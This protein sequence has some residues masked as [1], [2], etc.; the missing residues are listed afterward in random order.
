LADLGNTAAA[1]REPTRT[2]IL[3]VLVGPSGSGKTTIM[4]RLLKSDGN[5]VSVITC[6]TRQPREGEI[7]GVHYHFKTQDEFDT[8]VAADGL[9]E[10]ATVFGTS[11]GVPRTQVQDRIRRGEDQIIIVDWQGHRTLMAKLP[12]DVVSVFLIPPSVEEL[13]CRLVARGDKR[14]SI[15]KRVAAADD[16]LT[17][18][19]ETTHWVRND[20]LDDAVARV[21]SIL[22]AARLETE[23][24]NLRSGEPVVRRHLRC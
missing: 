6:T 15:D 2:G 16:D 14:D 1:T 9:L 4:D 12:E 22:A 8:L 23:R 5:L 11:Y 24:L 7:D 13:E 17:H 19:T 18:W 10:H 21:R 20:D 3:L